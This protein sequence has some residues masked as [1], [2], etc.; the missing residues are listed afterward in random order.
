MAGMVMVMVMVLLGRPE[1]AAGIGGAGTTHPPPT[2]HG[3]KGDQS[4]S[5]GTGSDEA[6][7]T[8]SAHRKRPG[9]KEYS[10]KGI[11]P[12]LLGVNAEGKVDRPTWKAIQQ[13]MNDSQKFVESLHTI[14]W[15]EGL[16]EDILKGVQSFLAASNG[17]D[18]NDSDLGTAAPGLSASTYQSSPGRAS[19][20][21]E[22]KP[23]GITTSAAKYSS[24]DAAVL[25]EYTV[26]LVEYTRLYKPYRKA[27]DYLDELLKEREEDDKQAESE[28]QANDHEME[29][30]STPEPEVELTEADLP[31]LQ[32]AVTRLQREY[33]DAVVVKNNL[34]NDVKSCSERLK[35]ATGLLNSLKYMEREWKSYVDE[36]TSSEILLSNCIA[37]AAFLTYCGAMGVDRRKRM[38]KFFMQVCR[39]NGLKVQHQHLFDRLTLPEFLKGKIV[40]KT[41]ENVLLPTDPISM[42]TICIFSQEECSDSWAL[43]CDPQRIAITW[44]LTMLGQTTLVKYKELRGHLETCLMEGTTLVVTDV[45]VNELEYDSRFYYI[46]RSRYRFLTSSTPFKLMVGENEIECQTGFRLV[47]A[48]T[49]SSRAVPSSIAAYVNVVEFNQ[50]RDGLEEM[51]LDRFLR[52]EKPRMQDT[53]TQVVDEM[54]TLMEG[55]REAEENIL[56]CLG[57][58]HRLLYN[59]AATKKLASIQKQHEEI[60]EGQTRARGIENS[61]LQSREGYRPIARRAAVMFDVARIMAEI[62]TAYQT[63]LAQFLIVFDAAIKHSER[64]AVKAVVERLTQSAFYTSARALFERD[65]PLFSLLCAVEVEDSSGRVGPGD[66]EFLIHPSFGA[67]V[68]TALQP[69]AVSEAASRTQAKKPFDWLL[70]EQYSYLQLLAGHF[71]WFQDA[72]DKMTKDGRETQWRQ[73]TEHDKPELVALPDGLDEK[74]SLI[75]RFMVIRSIRGDRLMPA[76]TCFVTSVLGKKYTTEMPLDLP[77]AYRQSESRTPIVLLYTQ[78]AN[79]VEKLVIEGAQKKQV[80]LHVLALANVG[81]GEERVARKLIHKAMVQGHWVLLHN[82]HNSPRLLAALDSFMHETK[83]VD[84]EFRL[85]VSVQPHPAI[86]SSLL[87]CAIKVV[88]DSPKNTKDSLQRSLQWVDS[89][90]IRVSSRQEWPALLHNLC[91]LHSL[92][93]L[94]TRYGLT[95]WNKPL[96]LRNF[97]TAELWQALDLAVREFQ[98]STD[99]TAQS[100][101]SSR[102]IQ[103]NGLRYMLAEAVYGRNMSDEFDRQGLSAMIDY[104]ISPAAVKREFEAAKIKYKLPSA[105]FSSHVRL[106][107][108]W[109]ALEGFPAEGL[110]VPE[111]CGLHPSPETQLGDEQYVFTRLNYLLDRMASSDTLTHAVVEPSTPMPSSGVIQQSSAVHTFGA[112]SINVA[113]AGIFASASLVSIRNRKEVELNEVCTTMLAKIPKV[114]TKESVY[115]RIKKTGGPNPFNLFVIAEMECMHRLLACVRE[116]L[117]SIKAATEDGLCGDRISEELLVAADNLYHLRIPSKWSQLG[118]D[119]SPPPTWSL[120]AWFTDLANR[121]SHI[122][123]IIVQGRE[124]VPAYWLGA[125]FNPRR[126]LS[127]IK[128]EAV[129]NSEGKPSAT[130]PFVFQTEITGRDK[131]HLREPP[132]DGMFVYGIYLWGCAW[133]K[134]TGDLLDAPPKLGPTPLPVVHIVALPQIE[135]ASLNDPVRAAVSYSCPCYSSRICQ[136]EPVMLLDVDNKDVPS[137]RWPLRGLSSTLRPF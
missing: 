19:V 32:E 79:M 59:L 57:S 93:R 1:F 23:Q 100:G 38:G 53:R 104:W 33:D 47:L 74:F 40:L 3:P 48:T 134:T 29:K 123:R 63:S 121:F 112:G 31:G 98:D 95:G 42:D 85:W 28:S 132:L 105:L 27:C 34:G 78:E 120:A 80:E 41:W 69:S 60:V 20:N 22:R 65:R 24:E 25:V 6:S 67:A 117:L 82:A 21:A 91:M 61:I 110:E 125:F 114:W 109:S 13:V 130:E 51:F 30:V 96:D 118:G 106:N 14:S 111:A 99:L 97:G 122:D 116:T 10:Q 124:K 87:Q 2:R 94:R 66:R 75:Q 133:E 92:I 126:F 35:A 128:Q 137:T 71:E 119:S 7:R 83:T 107:N 26:A 39:D 108:L 84:S 76:A 17:G 5:L 36:Y 37:A 12:P 127:I 44:V 81:I 18:V 43:L 49:F 45:D 115:D 86:P 62:N 136:R 55:L 11:Q 4:S 102:S 15:K 52:L 103:W 54:V 50:S 68:K 101:G 88:A 8:S 58:G 129:R 90:L 56:E 89:D 77:F 113:E 64:T 9:T 135:K 72:F 131:D 46:L 16:S 73:I 70:D